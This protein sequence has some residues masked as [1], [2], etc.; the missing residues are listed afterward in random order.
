MSTFE[1]FTGLGY[2]AAVLVLA[3]ALHAQTTKTTTEAGAV[4][5]TTAEATGVVLYVEGNRL[6]VKMVPA[7]PD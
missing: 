7:V 6:T 2:A 5:V 4:S 1:R 3:T